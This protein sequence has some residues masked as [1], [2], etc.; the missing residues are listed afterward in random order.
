MAE[1][2][3]LWAQIQQHSY[4]QNMSNFRALRGWQAERFYS[5]IN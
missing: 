2:S 3:S 4:W 5:F 1:L